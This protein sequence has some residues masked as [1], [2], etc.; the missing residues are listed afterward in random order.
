MANQPMWLLG[1]WE[2]GK[3]HF[4]KASCSQSCWTHS[5]TVKQSKAGK[6]GGQHKKQGWKPH[7]SVLNSWTFLSC[8]LRSVRIPLGTTCLC[9]VP[10]EREG[11]NQLPEPHTG[12]RDHTGCKRCYPRS[13]RMYYILTQALGIKKKKEVCPGYTTQHRETGKSKQAALSF[14]TPRIKACVRWDACPSRAQAEAGAALAPAHH[15]QRAGGVGRINS[16]TW[17]CASDGKRELSPRLMGS[18]NGAGMRWGRKSAA[19]DGGSLLWQGT[20]ETSF[21]DAV[22]YH[23]HGLSCRNNSRV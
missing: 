6:W 23:L 11:T 12:K 20:P 1:S 4:P 22:C 3:P 14:F 8:C 16:S 19:K 5:T 2:R 10:R 17:G 13:N 7:D 9:S 18:R 21:Q 15:R